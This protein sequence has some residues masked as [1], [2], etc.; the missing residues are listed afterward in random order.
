MR[1]EHAN[2]TVLSGDD[3]D[4]DVAVYSQNGPISP[5]RQTSS[6]PLEDIRR[7]PLLLQTVIEQQEERL[8]DSDIFVGN[9]TTYDNDEDDQMLPS[10]SSRRV[11]QDRRRDDLVQKV[12]FLD[13]SSSGRQPSR[14]DELKCITS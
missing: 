11:T 12:S 10:S 8:Y 14:Q 3:E 2:S 6:R 1:G 7:S 5:A 13:I 4:Y 9:D